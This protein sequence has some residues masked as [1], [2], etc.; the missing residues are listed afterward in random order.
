MN[1]TPN[2]LQKEFA[3]R[4]VYGGRWRKENF[5]DYYEKRGILL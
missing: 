3:R 5:Y 4:Y 2:K 1:I